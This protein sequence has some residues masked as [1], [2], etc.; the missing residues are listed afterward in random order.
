MTKPKLRHGDWVIVLLMMNLMWLRQGMALTI[1]IVGRTF[2]NWCLVIFYICMY[3]FACF[4]TSNR[5]VLWQIL[6]ADI[7]SDGKLWVYKM[8]VWSITVCAVTKLPGVLFHKC[9]L[10]VLPPVT[11]TRPK[12]STFPHLHKLSKRAVLHHELNN[13][14]GTSKPSLDFTNQPCM[15]IL[16]ANF[17]IN[18]NGRKNV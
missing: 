18:R 13:L 8:Y 15:S 14:I 5:T 16:K 12:I 11:L 10:V 2:L 9:P 7:L 6:Q 4:R 3:T 17:I 1:S